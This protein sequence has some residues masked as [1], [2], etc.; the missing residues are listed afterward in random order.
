MMKSR[1]LPGSLC[2]LALVALAGMAEAAPAAKTK[3]AKPAAATSTAAKDAALSE[4][5]GAPVATQTDVIG[6]KEAPAVFNIVPWKDKGMQ[7]PKKEV[8]TSILRETLQP[9]DRDVLRREI[10]LQQSLGKE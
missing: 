7:I 3:A 9:L 10:Q 8:N 2:C 1:F 5:L 6:S 4:A